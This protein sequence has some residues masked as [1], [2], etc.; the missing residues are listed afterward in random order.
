MEL[1][2]W[3]EDPE[4]PYI[5]MEYFREGD[6]TILPNISVHRYDKKPFKLFQSRYFMASK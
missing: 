5:A 6:L 3:L 4:T 2:G 1:L